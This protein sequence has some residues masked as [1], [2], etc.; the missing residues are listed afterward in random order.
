MV[1]ISTKK[2]IGLIVLAAVLL[3]ISQNLNVLFD[4][5]GLIFSVITPI[6]AGGCIAF[7]IN[8]PMSFFERLFKRKLNFRKKKFLNAI[9]RPLS[10]LISLI[11]LCFVIFMI[12]V[13]ILPEVA[14]TIL[15]IS[16][17]VPGYINNIINFSKDMYDKYPQIATAL[18]NFQ[19]NWTE[20]SRTLLNI[21]K[22]SAEALVGSTFIIAS[23]VVGGIT[24]FFLS[25]VMA[26]YILFQKEKIS[27]HAK[28]AIKAF[29]PKKWAKHVL[30]V[31]TLT[32]KTFSRFLAGQCIEALILGTLVFIG[33]SIFGFPY[34][35]MISVL[36]AVSSFIP[37][38]GIYVA[39]GFG[40]ILI[41]LQNPIQ[42]ILFFV[43]FVI[44]QQIEGNLIYPHVVGNSVGLSPIVVLT[45]II[46]GGG[47][48]G[49]VGMIISV[50]LSAVLCVLYKDYI[51][52]RLIKKKKKEK[53]K[54]KKSAAIKINIA[55]GN[56]DAPPQD[57]TEKSGEL[58]SSGSND[59][60]N[61][62][63]NDQPQNT[64]TE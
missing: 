40:A 45:A 32:S 4:A 42:G 35:L 47:L 44:I 54:K 12:L 5:I 15:T 22:A 36:I 55:A 52:R 56:N 48:F 59:E 28:R 20:I 49:F 6:I 64:K 17:S 3:V 30:R 19:I 21:L 11:I 43:M 53:K 38:F 13:I 39:S 63:K 37:M 18:E 50:P 34:A 62:K 46:V 14:N 51:S 25:F 57:K 41:A 58:S 33:M 8:L 31:A 2:I 16:N 29:L 9:A 26:I 1:K 24:S 61:I 7:V 60:D 10:F 27:Y 23:N